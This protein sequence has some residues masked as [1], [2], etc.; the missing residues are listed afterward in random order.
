MILDKNNGKELA[1]VE[2]G[3]RWVKTVEKVG[4]SSTWLKTDGVE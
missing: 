2:T 1:L 3:Q 4:V